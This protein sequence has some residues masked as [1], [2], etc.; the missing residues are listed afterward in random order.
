MDPII[1]YKKA[2]YKNEE[3][4]ER[5]V[6]VTLIITSDSLTT[7]ERKDIIFKEKSKYRCKKAFVWKIIDIKTGEKVDEAYSFANNLFKYKINEIV[8]EPTFDENIQNLCSKGIHFFLEKQ[9]AIEYILDP[10]NLTRMPD[11]RYN[12]YSFSGNLIETFSIKVGKLHGEILSYFHYQINQLQK[13]YHVKNGLKEGLQLCYDLEGNLS[14]KS[15]YKEDKLWGN[16]TEFYKDGI[17]KNKTYYEKG[18][19]HLSETNYYPDGRKSSRTFYN[20]G[21]RI[22]TI[23]WDNLGNVT[24]EIEH[25][26]LNE[27]HELYLINSY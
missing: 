13:K 18:N 26:D 3:N 1:G 10:N 5:E 12:S 11:G 4:E 14:E 20:M 27:T 21:K 24:K 23:K 8:E 15:Y 7:L 19:K 22:K 2:L 17:P 9:V 16:K 6:L 25:N